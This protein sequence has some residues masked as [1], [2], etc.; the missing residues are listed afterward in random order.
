MK[1]PFK[2][3]VAILNGRKDIRKKTK[4]QP[5]EN[6]GIYVPEGCILKVRDHQ[7]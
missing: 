3:N 6:G 7:I 5:T 1:E 4:T 2:V